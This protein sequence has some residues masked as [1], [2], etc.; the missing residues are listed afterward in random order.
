MTLKLGPLFS[1]AFSHKAPFHHSPLEKSLLNDRKMDTNISLTVLELLNASAM[2]LQ[3]VTAE[4]DRL[5]YEAKGLTKQ[6]ED[7]RSETALLEHKLQT[8]VRHLNESK[9]AD[10]NLQLETA[11]RDVSLFL[12]DL[13]GKLLALEAQGPSPSA[14]DV[15]H[16]ARSVSAFIT[17]HG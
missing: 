2:H 11:A 3:S 13:H 8:Y 5:L 10:R 1:H 7:Q 17:T 9:L 6:L 14:L 15:L 4:R 16:L 12:R